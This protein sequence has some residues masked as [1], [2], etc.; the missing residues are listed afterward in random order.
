LD[1][2]DPWKETLLML[3]HRIITSKNPSHQAP[4]HCGD[5][6]VKVEINFWLVSSEA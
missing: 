5:D 1:E 6:G 4:T 2:V 3:G